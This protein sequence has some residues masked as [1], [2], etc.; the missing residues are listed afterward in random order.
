MKKALLIASILLFMV[1]IST[2]ASGFSQN[3]ININDE[4]FEEFALTGDPNYD[5]EVF[6]KKNNLTKREAR[7]ILSEKFGDPQKPDDKL[8]EEITKT[9]N[10]EI[11]LENFAIANNITRDEARRILEEMFG[12]P[13]PPQER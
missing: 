8:F 2:Y 6:A 9:H 7:K 10:P 13:E 12:E 11:D 4:I 3:T 5:L 1:T